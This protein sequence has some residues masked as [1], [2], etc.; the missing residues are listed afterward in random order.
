M[1]AIKGISLAPD[2]QTWLQTTRQPRILHIFEN[3]CNLMNENKA[4]L[5]VVNP[6]IGNGPFN[7]V[8]NQ[9]INFS[10]YLD[11]NSEIHIR[12]NHLSIG[13][14]I[15]QTNSAQLW[16]AQPNWKKLYLQR[17]LIKQQA[18][19]LNLFEIAAPRA[20]MALT[21]INPLAESLI[22]TDLSSTLIN[23]KKLAGL[24][25]GLT[26]SG[27]DVLV[28]AMLAAWV[29]HPQEVAQPLTEKIA[30]ETASRTTSLSAA[31][32]KSTGKG[33]AG[34]LWHDFLNS[35]LA[36]DA[37]LI[38]LTFEKILSVGHSSGADALSGFI[39]TLNGGRLG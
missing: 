14:L 31:W 18:L 8:I 9:P 26:P 29:I 39:T 23:A 34:Y 10:E 33:E 19:S 13:S 25:P 22:N 16:H 28:G 27:D 5:S 38:K 36:E 15:I 17:L 12:E 35:L 1:P 30:A 24:G 32:L 21:L 20:G 37:D 4:I 6:S 11:L 3:S 2:V 7:L